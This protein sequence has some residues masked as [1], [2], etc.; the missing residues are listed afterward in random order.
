MMGGPAGCLVQATFG[1]QQGSPNPKSR[2]EQAMLLVQHVTVGCG[3]EKKGGVFSRTW[4]LRAKCALPK[5]GHTKI[6]AF[7]FSTKPLAKVALV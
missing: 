1:F 6:L 2:K 3:S 7:Q 4:G 5:L